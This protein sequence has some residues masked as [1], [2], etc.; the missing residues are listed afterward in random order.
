MNIKKINFAN[1]AELLASFGSKIRDFIVKHPYTAVALV[2]SAGFAGWVTSEFIIPAIWNKVKNLPGKLITI[3][4]WLLEQAW[5]H[6]IISAV[7]LAVLGIGVTLKIKDLRAIAQDLSH[8][9]P[10]K[11]DQNAIVDSLTAKAA[12]ESLDVNIKPE[13]LKT[14]VNFYNT[15]LLWQQGRLTE[16]QREVIKARA[17]AGD[18][19]MQKVVN[20]ALRQKIY[21]A[22]NMDAEIS[23]LNK[24]R[25]V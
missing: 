13:E 16:A 20:S 14:L 7:V 15:V 17:S 5:N 9:I 19:L 24:V 11:G 22:E 2:V 25:T 6:K 3:P 1:S 18:V 21:S 8:F 12:G 23:I 10:F 4:G